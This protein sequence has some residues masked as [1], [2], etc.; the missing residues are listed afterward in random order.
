MWDLCLVILFVHVVCGIMHMHL[1]P[2]F[3][4]SV[5]VLAAN[6]ASCAMIMNHFCWLAT[7]T[8]GPR[9]Q[10]RGGFQKIWSLGLKLAVWV[11]R[12]RIS[13]EKKLKPDHERTFLNDFEE[14]LTP[15]MSLLC[16]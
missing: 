5:D 8:L 15:L 9:K 13:I 12:A 14:N 4:T 11:F 3:N 7:K 2:L 16:T 10:L 6:A 1:D